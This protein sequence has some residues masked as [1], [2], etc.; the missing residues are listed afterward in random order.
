MKTKILMS[1]LAIGMAIALIGGAT[2]AWFTAEA[3]VPEQQFTAGTVVVSADGPEPA[4]APGKFFD[5]VNPGDCG[6]VKW[7]IINEGTKAAELRVKLEKAWEEE[8]SAENVFY[9]PVSSD[10]VMY[11]DED[12]IWLYYIGGPVAGTYG[13]DEGEAPE[14]V[15]LEL[16]VAFDGELTDDDYQ[17]LGFT[18][19]GKVYAIQA[20]NDAPSTV[21]GDAWDAV[22]QEGY[23]PSGLAAAYLEYI[24][25]TRCWEGNEEPGDPE[26]FLVSANVIVEGGGSVT[27]EGEYEEGDPVTLEAVA[28]DGFEFTGWSGYEGL[29]GVNVDGNTLTFNMPNY[30]VTVTA[31]FEEVQIPEPEI[32]SFEYRITKADGDD[33][34]DRTKVKGYIQNL[35]YDDGSLV[36]GSVEFTVILKRDGVVRASGT[37][38]RNFTNGYYSFN[39]D[40]TRLTVYG[41]DTDEESRVFIEINGIAGTRI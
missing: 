33:D 32:A 8:L 21:W 25:G 22:T 17:G 30:D 31:N 14:S 1:V 37:F 12:G 5:N 18:L 11:E 36:N 29:P 24:Q 7:T 27:G 2:M 3:D 23:E 41:Y 38:T 26:K 39:S 6:R 16:V 20:S 9:A 40:S 35:K 28:A 15:E 19:G 13:L 10:W 4:P 34:P